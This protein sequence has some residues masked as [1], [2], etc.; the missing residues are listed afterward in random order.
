MRRLRWPCS[1]VATLKNDPQRL[2]PA[3]FTTRMARLQPCPSLNCSEPY[4]PRREAPFPANRV[5][6]NAAPCCHRIPQITTSECVLRMGGAEGEALQTERNRFREGHGFSRADMIVGIA[7]FSP[8]G[9]L[10]LFLVTAPSQPIKHTLC[11]A[12]SPRNRSGHSKVVVA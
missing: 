4:R 11:A 12:E 9:V 8:W 10:L 6:H 7:G 5:K 3:A 2:K 1:A